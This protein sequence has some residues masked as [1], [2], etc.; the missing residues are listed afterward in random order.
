MSTLRRFFSTPF[1]PLIGL[2]VLALAIRFVFLI[3]FAHSPLFAPIEGGH[4]RTLYHHAAQATLIPDGAFAYLPLY[5]MA[6]HAVYA[7]FGPSLFAAA[8]LGIVC[9]ALTVFFIGAIALR[10]GA[11]RSFACAAALLY[12]LY[13]LAVLYSCLTMPNTLNALVAAALGYGLLRAPRDNGSAWVGLGLLAGLA[14]LGWAAWLLIV[15]A[16]LFYWLAIR[17]AAGPSPRN[18]ALFALAFALPLAPIAIHNS[19]AEG[20]F[21]LLTTHGGLNF[22][23]GNHERATGFPL[24]IREFR[25][26]ARAML[27]DA[28]HAAEK[29]VGHAL[30][31]AE[32]SAWWSR[33][34]RAFWRAHPAQ[35][36][37]LTARK[38]LYV[39]NGRDVD[40]LR[41]VEQ[42]QL[43]MP[44]YAWPAAGR[45]FTAI[46]FFGLLGFFLA[47]RAAPLRIAILAGAFSIALYFITA[48][49]RLA[50]APL[51]LGIGA[52][53][54][55]AILQ[56]IR[57]RG[58]I[59]LTSA[60]ALACAAAVA[61]P[62]P[63]P[64]LRAVDHYNAATQL[65]HADKTAEALN[66][67]RKGLE[68]DP[69][70]ANLYHTLGSALFK[71]KNYAD[72]AEA[73]ARCAALDPAH[74]QAFYN[75][76]LSLARTGDYCAA[77]DALAQAA[78]LRPLSEPAQSLA[79][80]LAQLCNSP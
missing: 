2:A 35:A 72:A 78:K 33:Q 47:P 67:A 68:I 69:H 12:A 38:L 6:L 54:A 26:T 41:M 11:R 65:L 40:D 61:W 77:R 57:T 4:D 42:A 49:Y 29:D 25:M 45:W 16:L 8:T 44:H 17:P 62:L 30:T 1:A 60:L 13:P 24:R 37:S 21:V 48:R 66:L 79:R 63:L 7:L 36:V 31:R 53:G 23:M 34:A 51:L 27:E 58:K 64:D 19:R 50:L 55:E 70:S 9:D 20:S 18:A 76:G 39:W 14:A 5:P 43:L 52:A 75:W 15:A 59:A 80:E 74:P 73:F 3:C 10:L 28:H 71:E 46:A 32:S 56:S 22:Y